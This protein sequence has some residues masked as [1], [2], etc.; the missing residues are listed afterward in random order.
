MSARVSL[1]PPDKGSFPLDHF[2]ECDR[3]AKQYT[4]CLQKHQLLPKRCRKFQV[5]YLQ[6]RMERFFFRFLKYFT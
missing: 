6:C 3:Q 2:H 5:D 4:D 1:K